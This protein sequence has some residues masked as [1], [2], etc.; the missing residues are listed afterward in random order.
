MWIATL[1]RAVARPFS[2]VVC[3]VDVI[4]IGPFS[5]VFISPC[6]KPPVANRPASKK[7]SDRMA[8]PKRTAAKSPCKGKTAR[9]RNPALDQRLEACPACEFLIQ[10]GVLPADHEV[11]SQSAIGPAPAGHDGPAAF[12]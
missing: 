7:T 5:G 9:R 6:I 8:S 11:T 4:S 2:Y 12:T 1:S 10:L 3:P